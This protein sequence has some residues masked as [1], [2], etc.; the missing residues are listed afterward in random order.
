M[1]RKLLAVAAFVFLFPLAAAARNRTDSGASDELKKEAA[2]FYSQKDWER[3]A[4]SYEKVLRADEKDVGSPKTEKWCSSP[5]NPSTV[6]R[7]CKE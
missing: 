1:N 4:V 2:E 6:K 7:P 5:K 3:A